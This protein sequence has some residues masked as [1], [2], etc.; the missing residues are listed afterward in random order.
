MQFK[1]IL[2]VRTEETPFGVST[3]HTMRMTLYVC[4]LPP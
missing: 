3:L 2:I 4:G 1:D